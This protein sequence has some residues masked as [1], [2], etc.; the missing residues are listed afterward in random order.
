MNYIQYIS[1]MA[2]YMSNMSHL[3]VKKKLKPFD[4]QVFLNT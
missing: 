4:C 2:L 1:Y 3:V